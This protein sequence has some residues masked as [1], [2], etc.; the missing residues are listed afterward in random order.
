ML[1]VLINAPPAEST[2]VPLRVRTF[3]LLVVWPFKSNVAPEA[4]VTPA[5]DPPSAVALPSLSR[6]ALTVVPPV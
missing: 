5:A 3:V 1:L 6:P 2:P 4:T